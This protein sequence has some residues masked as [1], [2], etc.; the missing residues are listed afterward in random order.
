MD[1]KSTDLS[2]LKIDRTQSREVAK[3]PRLRRKLVIAA[4]TVSVIVVALFLLKIL[5]P[6]VEVQ[7]ATVSFMSPAQAIAVLTASGYVVADRKAAV[8]SKGTGR[9]VYL[10]V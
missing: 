6:P 4:A 7:L 8:A 10:G 2:A 3:N 9:L 1:E 5:F